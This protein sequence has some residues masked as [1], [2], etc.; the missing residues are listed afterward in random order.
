MRVRVLNAGV[1]GY[2]LDQI[3]LRSERLAEVFDPE[4]ILVSFIPKDM[5][6]NA[7]S[8]RGAAPKPY[9]RKSESGLVLV[10][11]GESG[12]TDRDDVFRRIFGFSHAVDFIMLRVD[13]YYWRGL[14]ANTT[15]EDGTEIGCL[16]M[17]RL[18]RLGQESDAR[19][20][21]MLQKARPDE[22]APNDG[23][24]VLACA[25]ERDLGV[26]DLF[27]ILDVVAA[28][29]PELHESYYFGHMTPAG[30]RFVAEQVAAKI[31]A[32]DRQP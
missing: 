7:R 12:A 10:E 8:A 2:G 19:V 9:F 25:R 23:Q 28:G 5:E 11:A 4:L 3:V 21:V 17:D 16:L 22:I 15:G 6:R 29:D 32:E 26:I 20:I 31:R 13:P 24:V 14:S 1:P 27:P 30:N 18:R